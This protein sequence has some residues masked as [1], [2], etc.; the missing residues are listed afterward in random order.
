MGEPSTKKPLFQFWKA[1][2]VIILIPILTNVTLVALGVYVTIAALRSKCP[3]AVV[4]SVKLLVLATFLRLI[5][6][7]ISGCIQ[8]MTASVMNAVKPS[9][10]SG[11]SKSSETDRRVSIA[12]FF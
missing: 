1:I 4:L 6:L 2:R 11:G 3:K 5:W 8:S 12:T 9:P 7:I 10:S